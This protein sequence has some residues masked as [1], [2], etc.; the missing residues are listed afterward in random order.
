MLFGKS[1]QV[2][3]EAGWYYLTWAAPR[4]AEHTLTP[5]LLLFDHSAPGLKATAEVWY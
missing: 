2:L 5:P 4:G 1:S 3:L